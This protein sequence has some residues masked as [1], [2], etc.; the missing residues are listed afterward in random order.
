MICC[1]GGMH[2]SGTSLMAAWLQT[3]GLVIGDGP[4]MPPHPDNPKG[5]FEDEAFVQL[6]IRSINR[7]RRTAYG[8]KL[9]P[10]RSLTFSTVEERIATE[11]ITLRQA[12]YSD[13]GWKDPRSLLFLPQ[14]KR[15]IPELKVLFITGYAENAV[16]GNG[17]LA[18]HMALV[19]KPFSMD[20]LAAK[21]GMLL[22][23]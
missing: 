11:I 9:A 14:W 22:T 1:I 13:W 8:W 20:T 7:R 21:V 3:C 10:A 2:R 23:D 18:P 6:H 5:Y 17:Q 19:T 16:I 12:K 15:L 4:T